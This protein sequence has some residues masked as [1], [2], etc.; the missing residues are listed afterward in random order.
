MQTYEKWSVCGRLLKI[1]IL[2]VDSRVLHDKTLGLLK[3]LTLG[4]MVMVESAL[5]YCSLVNN[6]GFLEAS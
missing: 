3:K 6:G 5:S 2:I 4:V 1:F